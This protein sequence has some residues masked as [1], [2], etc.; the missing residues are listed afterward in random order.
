[1]NRVTHSVLERNPAARAA[2]TSGSSKPSQRNERME[3]AEGGDPLASYF[4]EI[5]AIKGLTL[6]EEKVLSE[7]IRAGDN[8][9]VKLLVEGN[10]KFVVAVCRNYRSQG[11]SMS[12]LISEGNLGLMRAARR[13]DGS[14][15]FKFISY[16]VWWIRQGILTALAEQTRVLNL[17]AGK[18][19]LIRKIGKANRKLA[20]KLG[21][22]PF[23][24]EVAEEVGISETEMDASLYLAKPAHSLSGMA[25][26]E[27]EGG[28]ESSLPDSA[29]PGTDAAARAWVL[30]KAMQG[31]L[32]V[33][34]EQE[35]GILRLFFGIG[36]EDSLSLTEI[37]QRFDVTRERIR[38]IKANALQKLRHPV[39]ARRLAA[40]RD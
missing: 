11:L 25:P 33:L 13:Y 3:F 8:Q 26:G 22:Q 16:A 39:R 23:S 40:L 6:A 35:N 14:L 1:V 29:A 34:T 31:M 27:E 5:K 28:N 4:R 2:G 32:G 18:V 21:R 7:R 37:A 9:A 24:L 38:Q 10:L 15:N 19:E 20:Q 17:S 12:D 36:R 30:S